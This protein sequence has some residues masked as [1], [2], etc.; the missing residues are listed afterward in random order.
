MPTP[1]AL[2][3]PDLCLL[4]GSLSAIGMAYFLAERCLW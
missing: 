4:G 3:G 1:P 2:R